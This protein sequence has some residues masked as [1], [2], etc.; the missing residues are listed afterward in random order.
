VGVLTL[1]KWDNKLIIAAAGSGKTTYLIKRALEVSTK[2]VLISTYTEANEAEI[3]QSIIRLQ[4]YVPANITIQTWFTFL[5]QHGVRPFQSALDESI[6]ETEIGFYLSS[7][8]SGQKLKPNGKPVVWKGRPQYWGEADFRK[9]YFTNSYKIYSDKISK[10]VFNCNNATKGDVINRIARIFDC[11]F[12][13]EVQDL[14]GYDLEL[15]K[16]LFKSDSEVLL[17]GDPRQVTYLT[18][19]SSKHKKYS[20]GN[21]RNFIKDQLGKKTTCALDETTLNLSHRNNQA[22]CDFSNKLYPGLKAC[23]PCT[24]GEC[25]RKECAAHE[26]IFWVAREEIKEYINLFQPTQ[27]RWNVKTACCVGSAAMN[28]G[29]SKGLSFDRVVIYPTR[30]MKRWLQDHN[31]PLK[32]EARAKLYVAITRARHSV[33]FVLEVEEVGPQKNLIQYRV[34]NK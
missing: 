4:G 33:A 28:F 23:K 34:K 7:N 9:F 25:C 12:I 6:H 22:I 5:L 18:H 15:L 11:I 26:G 1:P 19:H 8:K 30:E 21:I 20:N 16:L 31:H 14:A 17:V 29:E 27:L 3:R 10:F 2:Q 24:C 32:E 13:D